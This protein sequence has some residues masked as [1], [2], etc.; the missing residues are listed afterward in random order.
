M[1]TG[2]LT[3]LTKKLAVIAGLV[4]A[5]AFMGVPAL[6]QNNN[7]QPGAT[8]PYPVPADEP[9]PP[10]TGTQTPGTTTA[11][12][13][14]VQTPAEDTNALTRNLVEVAAT[15]QSFRTLAQAVEAAGLADTLSDGSY[16]I[17]APTNEAFSESL[18]D[19]A[20]EYLLR[21]E[22]RDLLRQVLTYHVIPNQ[23]TAN[24]L[25]TGSVKTLGGG[26]AVRV[27]PERVIVNDASV[28]Q[29]DIEASNGVI[30]AVNRVL[31]PEQLRQT[32]ASRLENNQTSQSPQ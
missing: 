13:N 26:V 9:T 24:Q 29:P 27:T 7:Q 21:P 6:A 2:T 5:S 15:N 4:G 20:V 16:T 31:L 19:G 11:P 3:Q 1:K 17:F 23:V 12:T 18:P 32:I 28:V 25:E 22:N 10:A 8:P 14:E 30:H